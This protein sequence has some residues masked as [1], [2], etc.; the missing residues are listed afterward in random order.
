MEQLGEGISVALRSM[1]DASSHAAG[2][3]NT[4]KARNV[5]EGIQVAARSVGQAH[6]AATTPAPASTLHVRSLCTETHTRQNINERHRVRSTETEGESSTE[7][8]LKAL[9]LQDQSERD[10]AS[11]SKRPKKPPRRPPSPPPVID[12][13]GQR[14]LLTLCLCLCASH[15]AWLSASCYLTSLLCVSLCASRQRLPR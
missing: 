11:T 4:Q 2:P 7:S 1:G 14:L 10:R 15:F 5:R 6:K 13:C 12:I 9:L 8:S 3:G